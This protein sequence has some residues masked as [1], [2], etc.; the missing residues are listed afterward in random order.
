[1]PESSFDAQYV[2]RLARIH[3]TETELRHIG[4][5]LTSIL[6]YVEKLKEVDVS[7]VEPT[8]HANPMSNVARRDEV[9][10]S[11][12]QQEALSNAPSE[13]SGLFIVPKIVE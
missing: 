4:S 11:L 10:G 8:A 9:Q 3:L 6:G 7:H 13:S 5:Q 2:A 12:H 1:M